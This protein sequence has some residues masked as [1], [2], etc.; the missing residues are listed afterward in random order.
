MLCQSNSIKYSKQYENNTTI[1]LSGP[2]TIN[3]TIFHCHQITSK[4]FDHLIFWDEISW[5]GKRWAGADATTARGDESVVEFKRS[6]EVPAMAMET[7]HEKWE[8]TLRPLE[9]EKSNVFVDMDPLIGFIRNRQGEWEPRLVANWSADWREEFFRCNSDRRV[10]EAWNDDWPYQ[11]HEKQEA[12]RIRVPFE[13][14]GKLLQEW[15]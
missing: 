4:K 1:H 9:L 10:S 3:S 8:L 5:V 11:Q 13:T 15:L 6:I 12:S 14:E 7:G 2:S